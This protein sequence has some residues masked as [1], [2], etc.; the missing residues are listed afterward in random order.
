MTTRAEVE[1][2][3]RELVATSEQGIELR[4]VDRWTRLALAAYELA[5][6]RGCVCWLVR[7]AGYHHE[8]VEHAA[9]VSA[10]CVALVGAA[11]AA[12]ELA[13]KESF[14]KAGH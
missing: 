3:K 13:A 10:Q 2:A 4:T 9:G 8:A 11:L 12:H 1:A 5:V 14:R 7:A 6:E